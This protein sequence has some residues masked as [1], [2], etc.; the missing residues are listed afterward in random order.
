MSERM[1]PV[2]A[3]LLPDPAIEPTIP[4]ARAAK[5]LGVGIRTA[6]FAIERGELPAIR[7]GRAIRVPTARFLAK[8]DLAGE[9]V[10]AA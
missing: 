3:Q 5:I 2:A 7:V 9:P 8:Y 1:D 10:P 6:Y 4:V